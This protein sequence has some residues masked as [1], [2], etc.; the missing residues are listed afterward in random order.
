MVIISLV[1]QNP[2]TRTQLKT[3]I[4]LLKP[5]LSSL[6]DNI[7]NAYV[8]ADAGELLVDAILDV[9]NGQATILWSDGT[10][11]IQPEVTVKNTT[12]Y[13]RFMK[14]MSL[15]KPRRRGKRRK[16]R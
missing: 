13:H 7:L 3:S 11:T 12:A 2:V 5:C 10:Q 1:V 8:A 14:M 15:D 4:H 16:K 6:P 9:S